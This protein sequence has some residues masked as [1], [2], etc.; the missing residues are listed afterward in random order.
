MPVVPAVVTRDSDDYAAL[1]PNL[2]DWR[3]STVGTLRAVSMAKLAPIRSP[4]KVFFTS[5]CSSPCVKHT[6]SRRDGTLY[7]FDRCIVGSQ[8]TSGNRIG[9]LRDDC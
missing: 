5:E 2:I 4:R 3:A 8:S 9:E 7:R 6:S 1:R